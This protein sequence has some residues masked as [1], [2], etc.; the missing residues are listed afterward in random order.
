[1]VAGGCA[2]NGFTQVHVAHTRP[3]CESSRLES[4]LSALAGRVS[5]VE[6]PGLGLRSHANPAWGKGHRLQLRL[7]L[8]LHPLLPR[9]VSSHVMSTS[10]N[11]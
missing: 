8:S 4:G 3:S 10:V 2:W 6:G 1:M 9:L 5:V 11:G 7:Q